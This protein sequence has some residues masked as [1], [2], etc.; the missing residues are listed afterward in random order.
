MNTLSNPRWEKVGQYHPE[1][2]DERRYAAWESLQRTRKK[3]H[4]FEIYRIT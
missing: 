3:A 2:V 4:V 1:D